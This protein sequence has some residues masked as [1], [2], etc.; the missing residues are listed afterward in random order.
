MNMREWLTRL[1]GTVRPA[2]PDADLEA[3]LRVHLELSA[4]AET[5]RS[6]ANA[7]GAPRRS[8]TARPRTPWT[9]C[10]IS[11]VSR[12]ST[13]SPATFDTVRGPCGG[14]PPSRQRPC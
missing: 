7:P 9:R 2:R 4:E 11:G 1:L 13:T 3:E 8:R 12:G 14:A 10:A 6:E 5:R